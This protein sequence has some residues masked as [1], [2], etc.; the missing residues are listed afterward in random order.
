MTFSHPVKDDE[1]FELKKL[2]GA[3]AAFGII[4]CDNS[5][6][7]PSLTIIPGSKI[8][9]RCSSCFAA[10]KSKGRYDMARA[11]PSCRLSYFSVRALF[12]FSVLKQKMTEKVYDKPKASVEVSYTAA[13][14]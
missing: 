12:S 10:S 2:I 3:G 1:S 13:K 4:A 7:R 5:E 6:S 14:I 9:S 11:W 8:H